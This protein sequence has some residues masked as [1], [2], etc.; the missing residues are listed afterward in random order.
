[1]AGCLNS[2]L[3]CSLISP[4]SPDVFFAEIFEQRPM[5][6]KGNLPSAQRS[7]LLSWEYLDEV[8]LRCLS[9][10]C[11]ESSELVIYKNLAP[12]EDYTSPAEA[13]LQGASLIINNVDQLW[14]PVHTF[15]RALKFPSVYANCYVTPQF[16]QTAPPHA[17]DRDVLV[18]QLEGEKHWSIY[19]SPVYLPYPSEQVGKDHLE[20]PC[21]VLDSQNTR[22]LQTLRAGDVLY[23]PRGFV[24]E[25]KTSSLSSLHL[26]VAIPTFDWSKSKVMIDALQ[27]HIDGPA[28][29]KKNPWRQSIPFYAPWNEVDLKAAL[30][31]AVEELDISKAKK[32]FEAKNHMHNHRQALALQAAESLRL[33]RRALR[34][35]ST[36]VWHQN[37]RLEGDLWLAS[38]ER[39]SLE[40]LLQTLEK[41][42]PIEVGH[43]F[44]EA[45]RAKKRRAPLLEDQ[46]DDGATSHNLPMLCGFLQICFAALCI[47]NGL[48]T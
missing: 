28:E 19:S 16:S 27:D 35:S 3:F 43:I 22:M 48:A 11:P 36:V 5:Y 39:I 9:L 6:F 40:Y 44:G 15:C 21:E 8:L 46:H 4:H 29:A 42:R 30:H 24:H 31:Q 33:P 2:E 13:Y 47:E 1:M 17:D 38:S 41:G 20:V 10:G 37:G 26:T 18:L 12:C 34:S 25:A 14:R 32:I 23:V 7:H 45:M